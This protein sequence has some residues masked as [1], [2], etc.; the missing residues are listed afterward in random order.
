LGDITNWRMTV[1]PVHV[2]LG[3]V[4][5]LSGMLN[6]ETALLGETFVHVV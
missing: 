2:T 1:V 4:V 3:R 6:G 5:P